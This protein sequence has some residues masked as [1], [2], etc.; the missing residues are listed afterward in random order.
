MKR[1][2]FIAIRN[3]ILKI[4][5]GIRLTLVL[6]VSPETVMHAVSGLRKRD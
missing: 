6:I 1:K 3:V 5:K 2:A 4:E